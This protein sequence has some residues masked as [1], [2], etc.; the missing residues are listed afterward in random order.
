MI[1]KRKGGKNMSL[2]I[3]I[4]P[5]KLWLIKEMQIFDYSNWFICGFYAKATFK[6]NGE[7]H[8]N[9]HWAENLRMVN[10]EI[11]D[12]LFFWISRLT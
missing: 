7:I 6:N 3:N 8:R 9:K 10:I 2:T 1:L 12:P 5:W 4:N 11:N